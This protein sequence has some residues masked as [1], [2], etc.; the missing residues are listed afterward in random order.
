MSDENIRVR[1]LHLWHSENKESDETDVCI[2]E[3]GPMGNLSISTKKNAN[4]AYIL[5]IR[6]GERLFPFNP[7][8]QYTNEKGKFVFKPMKNRNLTDENQYL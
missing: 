7:P 3:G 5:E 4:K 2:F 6:T 1:L 8:L